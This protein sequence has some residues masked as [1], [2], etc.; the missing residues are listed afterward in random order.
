MGGDADLATHPFDWTKTTAIDDPAC[1]PFEAADLTWDGL[2]VEPS[3]AVA[4]DVDESYLY[5]IITGFE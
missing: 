4:N 2:T 3:A 1:D 5:G